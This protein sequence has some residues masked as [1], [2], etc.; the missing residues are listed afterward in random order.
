MSMSVGDDVDVDVDSD[1]VTKDIFGR[2]SQM[3]AT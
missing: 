1:S 2:R 3:V